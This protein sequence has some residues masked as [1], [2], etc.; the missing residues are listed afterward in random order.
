MFDLD[1]LQNKAKELIH[2]YIKDEL[3]SKTI[4]MVLPASRGS[5]QKRT[6]PITALVYETVQEEM[7]RSDN[8]SQMKTVDIF[9]EDLD[10]I[11]EAN[12]SAYII[13]RNFEGLA[14]FV[15][16]GGTYKVAQEMPEQQFKIGIR[17]I[18]ER[19]T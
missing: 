4:Q 8:T 1:F 16:D 12:P 18:C 7:G 17:L 19:V 11:K 13:R 9:Y 10:A 15:I 5:K 6:Y 2:D 3:F 14:Q